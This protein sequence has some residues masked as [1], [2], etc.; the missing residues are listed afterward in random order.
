MTIANHTLAAAVIAGA[1]KQ[2]A[3]VLPLA[4]ASHFVLDALPHY[5][6]AGQG[7]GEALKHKLTYIEQ[8]GSIIALL[9]VLYLLRN[10]GVL[11]YIAAFVAIS[12]DLMWPYRYF[13]FE[14]LGKQ[15][16]GG[17]LTNFHRKI[18]WC[19]RPWGILVEMLAFAVLLALL[20]RIMP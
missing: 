15:P 17:Y 1:I 2:P 7:Y 18:Q 12:P 5:G 14:R 19:E 10:Q 11:S 8:S 13:F 3:L 20:L 16:P 9:T 6:Y 4:F